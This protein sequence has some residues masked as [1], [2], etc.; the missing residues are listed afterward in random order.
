[1]MRDSESVPSRWSR[2]GGLNAQEHRGA[3]PMLS[4]LSVAQWRVYNTDSTLIW[5]DVKVGPVGMLCLSR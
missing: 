3:A 2:L 1:M 4:A 5:V